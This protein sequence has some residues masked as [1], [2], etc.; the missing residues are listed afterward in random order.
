MDRSSSRLE[1]KTFS[2]MDFPTYRKLSPNLFRPT[3]D[4]VDADGGLKDFLVLNHLSDR[5]SGPRLVKFSTFY[6]QTQIRLTRHRVVTHSVQSMLWL[7][8]YARSH[9]H[10][11]RDTGA[12]A[13]HRFHRPTE[14]LNFQWKLTQE[15]E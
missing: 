3:P 15:S 14:I 13:G 12:G 4:A 11:L 7:R 6:L 5:T 1:K 2:M 10:V 9:P 8:W